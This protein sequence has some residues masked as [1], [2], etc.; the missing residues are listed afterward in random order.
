MQVRNEGNPVN[1]H[2]LWLAYLRYVGH[3]P[4]LLGS[5]F[6]RRASAEEAPK[7]G[8]EAKDVKMEPPLGLLLAGDV[9]KGNQGSSKDGHF[10][11]I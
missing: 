2:G 11:T 9:D 4:Y 5:S 3:P 7:E 1:S 8:E 6:G 10:A